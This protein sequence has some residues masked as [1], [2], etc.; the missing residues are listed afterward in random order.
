MTTFQW[1]QFV[2]SLCSVI[3]IPVVGY[4]AKAVLAL[5]VRVTECESKVSQHCK[6][7]ENRRQAEAKQFDMLAEI[8]ADVAFI[9]GQHGPKE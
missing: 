8:R 7:L 9:R 1:T 3:L 6:L 2:L 5:Q 4:F